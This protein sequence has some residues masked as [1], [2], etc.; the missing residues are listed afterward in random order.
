[1]GT[2][3]TAISSNDTFEDIY[4]E[5]LELYN[6]GLEVPEITNQIL[7]NNAEL[8]SDYEDKN[9]FWFAL[10]TAQWECGALN[11]DVYKKVKSIIESEEDLKLWEEL[12]RASNDIHKR[13]RVLD[14]FLDKIS[15]ANLKIRKRKKQIIRHPVFQKGECLVFKLNN[16]NYGGALVLEAEQGTEL[17]M[18]MLAV[19][20]IDQADKPNRITFENASILTE[21]DEASPGNYRERPYITWCYAQL[22]KK[23]QT[24]FEVV[25]RIEVIK[26]YNSKDHCYMISQWD[27]IPKHLD[28]LQQHESAHGKASLIVKLEEWR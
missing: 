14:K 22:Y 28:N 20:T 18:N 7:L 2:W 19:T 11:E 12:N 15:K 13:K 1:M 17:G 3:G 10:A 25:G 4:Q 23:A 26:Q 27:S 24:V 16:G 8:Q 21:K 9:N 6:N 5:F